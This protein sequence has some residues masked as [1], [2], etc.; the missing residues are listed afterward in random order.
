LENVAK[1]LARRCIEECAS[2]H[3]F[4]ASTEIRELG[5]E[6]LNLIKKQMSK[7]SRSISISKMIGK[8]PKGKKSSI[9]LPFI[10]SEV[11]ESS[12]Q[13]LTYNRGLFTQCP[14]NQMDNG[15]FC[16]GCQAEADK[17]AS[18]CPNC[19]TVEQR[20]ATG[21]YDFKDP[22]GRSPMSYVKLLEK[23]SISVDQ[24]LASGKE[25]DAEHF[26]TV[27]KM[28]KAH[29][30]RP[31]KASASIVAEHVNDLFSQLTPDAYI[32]EMEEVI[33]APV[34]KASK[35]VSEEDKEAKKTALEQ[36]REVKKAALEQEREVKKAEREEQ[37]L[38]EKE[39]KRLEKEAK[40]AQEKAEKEAK[41]QQEKEEKEEK[42]A[43]KKAAAAAKPS[44]K[45]AKEV[46]AEPIV[47]A[48]PAPAKVSVSRITIDDVEY[49]K[50]AS[51]ILYNVNTKEEVGIYDPVTKTM[52]ELPEED[53]EEVDSEYESSAEEDN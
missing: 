52:K 51:N 18:G 53:E 15:L 6:N 19:G 46:T 35:K 48:V 33:E 16:M 49:L 23:L 9:P 5:L 3:D 34:K 13:G 39:A 44:S 50:S 8:T 36:E 7:K 26:N 2:R 11:S 38:A 43:L 37:R 21:L 17:N 29:R 20:L 42:E 4:D 45:K 10:A 40:L 14:K 32:M 22:K 31:K 12:C 41:R 30:G 28:S 47:A 25:I 27:E 1:D 24:A